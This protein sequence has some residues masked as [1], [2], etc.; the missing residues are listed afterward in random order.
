M[1]PTRWMPVTQPTQPNQ[2]KQ[3]PG[4]PGLFWVEFMGGYFFC[5]HDTE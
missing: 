4:Y 5:T 1:A 3:R 2:T